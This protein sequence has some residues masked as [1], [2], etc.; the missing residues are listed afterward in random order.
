MLVTG[1]LLRCGHSQLGLDEA[2][3]FIA[4]SAAADPRMLTTKPD[5]NRTRRGPIPADA[6]VAAVPAERLFL[7]AWSYFASRGLVCCGAGADDE[8]HLVSQS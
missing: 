5:H 4:H 3:G 2:D 8:A 7:T 6:L 1:C